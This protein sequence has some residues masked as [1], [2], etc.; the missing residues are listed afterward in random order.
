MIVAV[1]EREVPVCASAVNADA[2]LTMPE[3]QLLDVFLVVDGR[4]MP[5]DDRLVRVE[6]PIRGDALPDHEIPGIIGC[7]TVFVLFR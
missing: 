4:G 1:A 3:G 6:F 7:V 5:E 2:V